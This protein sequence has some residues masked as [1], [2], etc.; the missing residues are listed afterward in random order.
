MK[1]PIVWI[2]KQIAS[3]F[4]NQKKDIDIAISIVQK[5][6]D[7]LYSGIV[8]TFVTITP[9]NIDNVMLDRL[10][11]IVT[12]ALYALD[13]VKTGIGNEALIKAQQALN[14]IP[15]E[16]HGAYWKSLAGQIYASLSGVSLDVAIDKTQE[17]YQEGKR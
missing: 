13:L 10:K 14:A 17:V 4:R 12:E 8:A 1:N 7:A 2:G 16:E 5:L 6:K 9:T 3:L 11:V 15:V